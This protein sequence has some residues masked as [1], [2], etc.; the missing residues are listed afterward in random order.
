MKLKIKYGLCRAQGH[1]TSESTTESTEIAS[2]KG[3]IEMKKNERGKGKKEKEKRKK[4]EQGWK[5]K[6]KEKAK[7]LL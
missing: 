7:G 5:G 1:V 3:L 2:W 6:K 4:K